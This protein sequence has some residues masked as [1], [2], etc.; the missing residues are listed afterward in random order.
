MLSCRNRLTDFLAY[1]RYI[2]EAATILTSADGSNWPIHEP[3]RRARLCRRPALHALRLVLQQR[4]V[5]AV[6]VDHRSGL[7]QGRGSGLSGNE[8]SRKVLDAQGVENLTRRSGSLTDGFPAAKNVGCG[9]GCVYVNGRRVY[10]NST[11]SGRRDGDERSRKV[12]DWQGLA[13]LSRE[14]RCPHV[15]VTAPVN[16]LR[17]GLAQRRSNEAGI[18]LI[19]KHLRVCVGNSSGGLA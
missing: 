6:G 8:R 19:A 3:A 15:L 1:I 13:N 5:G 7:P 12:I 9:L 18:L 2:G 11:S 16:G 17:A 10:M 14:S 4:Y